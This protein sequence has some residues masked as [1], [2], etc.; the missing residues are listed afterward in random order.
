MTEAAAAAREFGFQ[1][2][3]LTRIEL[4]AGVANVGSWRVAEKLGMRREGTARGAAYDP[5]HAYRFGLQVI[6]DGL[7]AQLPG[8]RRNDNRSGGI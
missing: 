7:A 5:E 6:L 4:R 2:L 8:A 3:G 1:S